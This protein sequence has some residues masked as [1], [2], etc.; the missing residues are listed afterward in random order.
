[1]NAVKHLEEESS[2]TGF[3][4][5]FREVFTKEYIHGGRRNRLSYWQVIFLQSKANGCNYREE[6]LQPTKWQWPNHTW[7][8]KRLNDLRD[9]HFITRFPQ[10]WRS[11]RQQS[12][13]RYTLA[14]HRSGKEGCAL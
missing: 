13:S 1:M 4:V 10:T 11:A 3:A 6:S 7:L 5:L 2:V 12:L 8:Q 9:A 14:P